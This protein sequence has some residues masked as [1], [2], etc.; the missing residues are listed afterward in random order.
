MLFRSAERE[1]FYRKADV[2]VDTSNA[3][4]AAIVDELAAQLEAAAGSA[5]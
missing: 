1:P 3:A 4:V 5:S 2:V